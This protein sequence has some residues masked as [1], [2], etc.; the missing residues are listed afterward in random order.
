MTTASD[1]IT[2]RGRAMTAAAT[3]L[4]LLC[5]SAASGCSREALQRNSYEM[6][7]TMQ[8]ERCRQEGVS[9][10]PR[11]FYDDYQRQRSELDATP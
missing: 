7:Q 11:T 6:M 8:Q 2:R 9:C 5:A 4:A 3:L 10:P 1:S